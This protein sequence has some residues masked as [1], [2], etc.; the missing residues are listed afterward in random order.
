[1]KALA[2]GLVALAA[3]SCAAVQPETSTLLE[4]SAVRLA[5][6]EPVLGEEVPPKNAA[7]P[8]KP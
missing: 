3:L 5:H 1:M 7:R 6:G 8:P 4:D 2:Y